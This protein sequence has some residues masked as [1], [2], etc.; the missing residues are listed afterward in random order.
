MSHTKK[1]A[2][3]S[4]VS[5]LLP[6]DEIFDCPCRYHKWVTVWNILMMKLYSNVY[7][8]KTVCHI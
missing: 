4:S 5:E 8:V 3:P 7:E 1:I 2:F 6:R